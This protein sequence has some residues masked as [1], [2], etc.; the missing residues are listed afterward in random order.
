MASNNPLFDDPLIRSAEN[1]RLLIARRNKALESLNLSEAETDRLES[2]L[3]AI[4]WPEWLVSHV[5]PQTAEAKRVRWPEPEVRALLCVNRHAKAAPKVV[6]YKP[7]FFGHRTIVHQLNR[8]LNKQV[9]DW[10]HDDTESLVQLYRGGK[11]FDAMAATAGEFP[12]F[13]VLE[14][15]IVYGR[16][17]RDQKTKERKANKSDVR[18]ENEDV[19]DEDEE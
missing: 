15:E 13:T 3:R 10:D 18:D 5:L 12:N 4:G 2:E 8:T 6:H 7:D 9:S 19:G 17:D 1:S 14:L 16:Y 11:P